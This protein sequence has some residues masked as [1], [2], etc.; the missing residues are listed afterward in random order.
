[1]H[2]ITEE[3]SRDRKDS[4]VNLETWMSLD[5][6]FPCILYFDVQM[7]GESSTYIHNLT[8][9]RA[10]ICVHC[11]QNAIFFFKRETSEE[12]KKSQSIGPCFHLEK[13]PCMP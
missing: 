12:E 8:A 7:Y 5:A 9:S 13:I 2:G 10:A 3:S 6:A 4:F 11:H 1:V